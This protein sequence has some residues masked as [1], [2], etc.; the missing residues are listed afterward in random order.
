MRAA[1]HIREYGGT[2]EH[3][4]IEAVKERTD[5]EYLDAREIPVSLVTELAAD[6]NGAVLQAANGRPTQ[7][8]VIVP[9][10]GTLRI[11]FG[12][13]ADLEKAARPGW[14][15]ISV[16]MLPR[17]DLTRSSGLLSKNAMAGKATGSAGAY[18]NCRKALVQ[19]GRNEPWEKLPSRIIHA[20]TRSQ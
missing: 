8:Y 11:S 7:L 6:P 16:W 5:A 4:W 13:G 12:A 2:L 20:R 3:F 14:L 18:Q 9:M 1:A 10:D 17:G 15:R 19:N